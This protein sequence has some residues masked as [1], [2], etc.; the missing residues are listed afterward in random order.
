MNPS[1]LHVIA[2]TTQHTH[3]IIFLHGRGSNAREFE[4]EFFESQASDDRFLNQI[5][6]SLNWV[7]PCA[8]IR[9]AETEKEDMRQWFDTTSV[10]EPTKDQEI[11]LP[12][13]RESV[14][15]VYDIIKIEVEEV[16]GMDK[17]FLGGISQGSA[18]AIIALLVGGAKIAGFIGLSSWL[19]LREEIGK[20]STE[21]PKAPV[22]QIRELLYPAAHLTPSFTA[23]ETVW[24]TPILLEHTMDDD[25]VPLENG[26]QLCE[27]LRALGMHVEWRT[28][29][30][31]GH[32]V[33]EPKGIDDMVNF[34]KT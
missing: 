22:Q 6:P 12:G 17:I 25:V 27:G 21:A 7:F 20:K 19:P 34:L 23:H 10:R 5:F 32:W 14:S 26:T 2:P 16:G 30:E 15:F 3:T 18:T 29:A 31:G 1:D 28:Y 11:Q 8:A 33:N 24:Q 4:S 13:L 9:Y